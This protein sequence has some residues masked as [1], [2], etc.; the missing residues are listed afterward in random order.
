MRKIVVFSLFM[1]CAVWAF[2]QA[3][4]SQSSSSGQDQS[5]ASSQS[6]NPSGSE[7]TV[8]GCVSGSSGNYTLTDTSGKTWQLAGDTAKLDEHVGHKISVTGTTSSSSAGAAGGAGSTGASG[9]A[10]S[11]GTLTVTSMKHISKTCTPGQ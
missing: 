9:G 1:L 11:G 7:M 6:S 3:S 8:E 5:S 4:P 2:A 10:S